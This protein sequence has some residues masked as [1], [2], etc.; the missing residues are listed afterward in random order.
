MVFLIML[1]T[2]VSSH[3][4][5]TM[6][7]MAYEE[8]GLAVLKWNIKDHNNINGVRNPGN[9][10]ITKSFKVIS[11]PFKDCPTKTFRHALATHLVNAV[12][13]DP[14]IDQNYVMNA[15]GHG[16]YKTTT[17]IYGSHNMRVSSEQRAKR[18]ASVKKAM[19]LEVLNEK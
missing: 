1:K 18:R 11:S 2:D 9:R 16:Q 14:N 13:S 10:G 12:Q 3:K 7:Y 5:R 17:D 6:V 15:I 4:F 8:N 19:N